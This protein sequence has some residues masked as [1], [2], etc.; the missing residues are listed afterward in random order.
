MELFAQINW[1][2]FAAYL[3][4][5]AVTGLFAGM[6]GIGGGAIMVPVLAML[7]EAQGVAHEHLMHIAIA[8]AMATIL[9]TSVSS[10]RAHARRGAVRWKILKSLAPGIVL[11]GVLGA[12]VADHLSTFALALCFTVFVY[13]LSTNMFFDRRE[14]VAA[15]PPGAAGMFA[16][17]G[18]IGALSSL[19]AIGGAV[20]SVPYLMWCGVSV[21][22]AIGTAAAIGF[23]VA[24]GG[25]V[26]YVWTGWSQSGLPPHSLGFVYLP[27]TFGMAL[28]SVCTAPIGAKAAHSLPTKMLKK[29]FALLLFALATRMLFVIW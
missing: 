25:T 4:L 24:F 28:A 18:A 7:L 26:G 20:M 1:S 23:P 14:I 27:A 15:K 17:G 29:I 2:L 13:L 10:V 22:G 21:I 12:T 19:L 9:F 16:A 3:A 11:G 6:L 5:G 8:T